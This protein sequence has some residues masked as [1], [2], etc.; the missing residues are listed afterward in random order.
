MPKFKVTQERDA[1]QLWHA[2]IEAPDKIEAQAMAHDDQCDWIKGEVITYDDRAIPFEDIE[3][4]TDTDVLTEPKVR[5]RVWL[6]RIDNEDDS[7]SA[8][9][10]ADQSAA[11]IAFEAALAAYMTEEETALYAGNP[12]AAY[13]AILDREDG[14]FP[15]GHIVE[16]EEHTLIVTPQSEDS[17]AP[18]SAATPPVNQNRQP[19]TTT[20]RLEM[21][22]AAFRED[23][24]TELALALTDLAARVKSAGLKAT[25]IQ[26]INGNTIGELS[27]SG[28]K[29]EG[30]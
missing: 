7:P 10:Y 18:D 11:L 30:D 24:A 1:I 8:H 28:H 14:D 26:D 21:E 9:I 29:P 5:T 13:R 27:L 25:R 2:L 16:L 4:A 3:A 17:L 19:W 6:L 22:N 15:Y 12:Q 20:I 23:P